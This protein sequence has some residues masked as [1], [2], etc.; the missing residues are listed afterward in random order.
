MTAHP[1]AEYSLHPDS[2]L[3]ATLALYATPAT[4]P[5]NVMLVVLAFTGAALDVSSTRVPDTE[6]KYFKR[7]PSWTEMA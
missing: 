2:L 7:E 1:P 6:S 3:A 5:L 4:A